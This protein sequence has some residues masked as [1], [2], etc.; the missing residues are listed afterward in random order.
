MAVL[1]S[2][3]PLG[4][5]PSFQKLRELVYENPNEAIGWDNAW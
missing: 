1:D 4:S 3:P 2:I 5:R